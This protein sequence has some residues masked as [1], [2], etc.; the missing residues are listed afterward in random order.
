MPATAERL[1]VKAESL[2]AGSRR[3]RVLECAQR[4]KSTW[5][6]LG[7]ALAEVKQD[8]LWREWGHGSFEAYCAKELFLRKATVEKLVQS[9]GF[10]ARHEPSL[11]S[12]E[13]DG[14]APPP[15]EV[16]EVLSRAE[17]AGRLPGEGWETLREE[18]LERPPTPRGAEPPD[19]GAVG[20]RAGAGGAARGRP[21][22]QAHRR[23]AAAGQRLRRRGAGATD[24]GGAGPRAGR[25]P[26]GAGRRPDVR[27]MAPHLLR[28]LH[29][30]P[31][32]SQP[33]GLPSRSRRGR[34]RSPLAI[35]QAALPWE[36][37]GNMV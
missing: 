9:F 17:A 6:E 31:N 24:G 14:S 13:R 3:R 15:F 5:V 1:Q 35:L 23:R 8:G 22:A 27:S 25:G 29:L 12:Q 2:P 21:P 37:R 10:L 20:A 7:R 30:T 18:V 32:W 11:A 4:F 26:R 34:C 36:E 28:A 33:A 19:R 16:I